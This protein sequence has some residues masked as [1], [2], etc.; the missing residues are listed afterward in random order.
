MYFS[1]TSPL[2]NHYSCYFYPQYRCFLFSCAADAIYVKFKTNAT[3]VGQVNVKFAPNR[4]CY[5]VL[6]TNNQIELLVPHEECSVSRRR[7]VFLSLHR[8][9]PSSRSFSPPGILLEASVSVSFHPEFTT[10]ADRLFH[11]QCFHKKNKKGL[12]IGSATLPPIGRL[13]SH[14]S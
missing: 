1:L 6:V 13:Y 9:S 10:A 11:F 3:F 14:R 4:F 2:E 12:E 5:Q 8:I 7:L